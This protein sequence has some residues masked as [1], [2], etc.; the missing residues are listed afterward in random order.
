[1]RRDL[2]GGALMDVGCYCV[3][4]ARLLAGEPE[5]AHAEQVLGGDGVDIVFAGELRFAGGVIASLRLRHRAS[6]SR[7]PGGRGRR[8]IA[9]RRRPLARARATDRAVPRDGSIEVVAEEA[10]NAYALEVA[11]FGAA[12]L[13]EAEPLLGRDDALGQSRALEAL[14]AAAEAGRSVSL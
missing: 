2:D 1:M 12:I 10:V 3:S 11:N 13:G 9:V 8:G 14:Y 7:R 4:C 6:P 5:R